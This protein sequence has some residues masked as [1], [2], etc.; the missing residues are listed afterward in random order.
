MPFDHYI[1][2]AHMR[3]WATNHRVSMLQRGRK[4]KVIEVGK[5]VAAE[6]GLNDPALEAAYGKVEDAFSRALRRLLDFSSAPTD[7]EWRAV[8]EYTV[9]M[10]DRY[11]ALRGSAV[12]EHGVY[13][14]NAIMAPNPANWGNADGATAPLA[15]LAT[16]MDREQLKDARR[17]LLSVNAQL[18]PRIT[19]VFRVGPM[20]LGDAGVHA[21]TLRPDAD[22]ERTYVAMPLSPDAMVVF[23][24]QNADDDEVRDI[25]RL[26]TTKV[27]MEST[28]VIDTPE[29]P[30][31]TSFVTEMWSHQPEP[32]GAGLPKTVRVFNRI[33]DISA[34]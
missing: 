31:I 10:H 29:A 30:V 21:L 6:Q 27:A 15:Q 32:T 8:R 1:S 26:L 25:G 24:N 34:S 22:T 14:G 9:L 2:R 28:V 3:Q 5:K 18:L 4:P 17:Q 23:G 16:L 7:D 19:Q 33:D 11:P 12:D 20:L 13:G